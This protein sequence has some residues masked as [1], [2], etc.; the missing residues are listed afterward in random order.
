MELDDLKQ[1]WKQSEFKPD[2]NTDIMELIHNK[3]YGPLAALKRTFVKEIKFM[4]VLPIIIMLCNLDNI[5]GVLRSIMFWSYIA[6]C[7]GL[8][9]FAAFNY[10]IVSRMEAMDGMVISNLEQQIQ[11]LERRL[12]A[13][14]TA[15][16]IAMLYFI[17]LT[18]VMPYFQ[19]YR[20]LSLWHAVSPVARFSTYA[21]L[22]IV[23]YFTSRKVYQKKFGQ[24]LA[25]LKELVK[26]MS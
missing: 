11:I 13:N 12:K 24:Y 19:H 10:R 2:K 21:I 4:A 6:F 23:Q 25:Y 15:L 26:E 9:L 1:T 8:L 17:V 20:T 18:E 7:A 16:R 5:G 22:L 3:K 14:I